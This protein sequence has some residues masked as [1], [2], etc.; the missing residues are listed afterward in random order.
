M[1]HCFGGL[2]RDVKG[3]QVDEHHMAFGAARHDAQP[4]VHELLGHDRRILHDLLLIGLEFRRERFA[5]RH[6]LRGD[7]V[8][9]GTALHAREDRGVD[10][11][12]KVGTHEDHAAAR[13]AQRLVGG[14]GHNVG[15][16][17][18]RRVDARGDEARIVRHVDHQESADLMRNFRKALEVDP[19]RIGRCPGHD[20]LRLIFLRETLDLVDVDFLGFVQAV[21]NA[22]EVLAGEI[23]VHAV[24]EVAAVGERKPHE[25]VAR[26]KEPEEDGGIGLRARMRLHVHGHFHAGGL[27]EELLRALDGE[28]LNLVDEFAAAV[29]A[30]SGIAFRVLVGEAASLS[31]HHRRRGIVFAGDKLDILFLAARFG[32][33]PLPQIRIRLGGAVGCLEHF[34]CCS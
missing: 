17:E 10:L 34:Y 23:E 30:L 2:P 26:L 27:A 5:Q 19:L 11:L 16:S 31:S 21:R 13:T 25:R 20:E 24:R 29:I 3:P 32:V 7:D 18:R 8:H 4:P 22:M 9:E 6:G 15:V 28:A 33:N 12:F 1:K 14:R